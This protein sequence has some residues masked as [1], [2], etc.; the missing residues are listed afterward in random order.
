MG[1]EI[2]AIILLVVFFA[3]IWVLLDKEEY[4]LEKEKE[5][6]NDTDVIMW[7]KKKKKR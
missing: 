1:I 2:G 6:E 7:F 3:T 4:T 5:F